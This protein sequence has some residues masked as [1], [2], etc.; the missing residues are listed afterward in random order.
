MR[1]G[2]EMVGLTMSAW[3]AACGSSIDAPLAGNQLLQPDATGWV[4]RS[5]TGTTGIQGQWHAFAD[6]RFG[7][8]AGDC[9]TTAFGECSL[10]EEPAPGSTYA[11]TPGLGMC[12]SGVIARWIAGSYGLT[13]DYSP[14]WAGIVLELDMPDWPEPRASMTPSA[15]RA[16][17]AAAH[18]VTGFAFDIDSEPAPGAGIL[19]TVIGPRES[20]PASRPIYW[21]G[22][23]LDASPVHA[24]HNE[25]P[26]SDVGP[27]SFD[28]SRLFRIGFLVSGNDAS[29]VIYNFCIN[30]LTALRGPRD[31]DPR[32]ASDDQLLVPD[33]TGWVAVATT[34]KT[35]IQGVWFAAA[36]GIGSKGVAPGD[37]Q[38]A[39]HADA[40]C[41]VVSEPDPAAPEY[42]PTKDLGMCTRGIVGKAAA[43]ADGTPD[44]SHVWGAEIVF[45]L[46]S[47]SF[48]DYRLDTYDAIRNGVTG[49]AFD[50]DSEPAPGAEIRVEL[51]TLG[52]ET[53]PAWWGGATADRSPVHAGHNEV[54]LEEVGGPLYL[55]HPPRL[56]E[57]K[58]LQIDFLIPSNASHAVSYSF[59]INNLTALRH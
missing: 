17:D 42:P 53:S 31:V 33:E 18:G 46:S 12:T 38:A 48:P 37:C 45:A 20:S 22:A 47:S 50:I 36:D 59:C 16:Y 28:G 24:G 44:Y 27:G 2:P 52:T 19:A 11:P 15:G 4:D 39:G 51:P 25:F 21:G 14:G 5:T 54:R 7:T 58:L 41:S 26:W 49:F 10:V 3:A 29:A 35:R 55:I 34:G 57:S 8:P 30:N 43:G 13:P 9:R 6:S 40:A 23:R 56:E 32:S 1:G